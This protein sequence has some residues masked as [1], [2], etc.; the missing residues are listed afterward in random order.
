MSVE[1][2]QHP[3]Y[4]MPCGHLSL[5]HRVAPC[6]ESS[7]VPAIGCA[8]FAV[9]AGLQAPPRT[10]VRSAQG[11]HRAAA[12]AL[13]PEGHHVAARSAP[14]C[15]Q[16]YSMGHAWED[17]SFLGEARS[18]LEDHRVAANALDPEEHRELVSVLGGQ[19]KAP[20]GQCVN[21]E[22]PPMECCG[23]SWVEKPAAWTPLVLSV[24]PGHL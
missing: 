8:P 15:Q 12:S 19:M 14:A 17:E 9:L 22:R 21:P 20:R 2:H 23:Q 13:D 6:H 24:P 4:R 1:R 11:G 10:L 7:G 16:H 18:D 5:L 3:W